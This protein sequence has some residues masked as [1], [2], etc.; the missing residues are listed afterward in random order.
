MR[1]K[2]KSTLAMEAAIYDIVEE[3][4]PITVRGVCYGLFVQGLIDS[5]EKK[6]TAKVSRVMTAMRECGDLE[7]T[8]VVDDG[9]MIDRPARW[10]DPEA[11]VSAAMR[12][13]R[14]NN[15]QDQDVT[16]EVWS[17][18]GTVNGV[19]QPVLD[20]YGVTFRVMKGFG[21]F[22]SV[23]QAVSDA[24][25]SEFDGKQVIALYV[26]D[27]DP[28]GRH[29]SDEDL[30]SRIDRY[31]GSIDIRRVAITEEDFHL[32]SFSVHTKDG[33][34]RYQWFLNHH[35]SR[36]W[37]LDAMNPND[38]RER[39]AEQIRTCLDL[40]LWERSKAVERA[41]IESMQGFRENLREM[42]AGGA[43]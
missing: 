28:S 32:E 25:Y 20:E 8:K 2:A 17:E 13:Y 36:C 10:S 43:A 21:S 41:E 9:R 22:T 30:P 16:V 40:G 6:N 26:G 18:K 27:H 38:L 15:W 19:I 35:G 31:G 5:M 37:E 23:M 11:I 42:M 29:M 14:R 24:G 7:W 12:Q 39:L 3:R 4:Y 1:G 33:D 34:S